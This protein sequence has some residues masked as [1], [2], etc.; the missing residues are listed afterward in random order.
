LSRGDINVDHPPTV[1]ENVPMAWKLDEP[2][3]FAPIVAGGAAIV[4]L[5]AYLVHRRAQAI[6]LKVEIVAMKKEGE[7]WLVV[8]CP[9]HALGFPAAIR[10]YNKSN[11]EV[12][13]VEAGV[14][15][16]DPQ[17]ANLVSSQTVTIDGEQLP[18]RLA[19]RKACVIP[20]PEIDWWRIAMRGIVNVYAET[21]EPRKYYAKLLDNFGIIHKVHRDSEKDPK[22]EKI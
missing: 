12:T 6:G 2:A 3:T 10:I 4:A 17:P 19:P 11:F 9:P 5:L 8:P 13:I 21:D 18:C 14:R 20:F 16:R 7:E 1:R 15:V 22:R